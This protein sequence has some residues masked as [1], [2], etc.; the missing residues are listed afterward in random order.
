VPFD[1]LW[2]RA[3]DV[4]P[5]AFSD[6]IPQPLMRQRQRKCGVDLDCVDR[7]FDSW[8]ELTDTVHA[9]RASLGV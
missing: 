4:D 7:G 2:Q 9:V 5:F 3:P 6:N 8:E 1:V